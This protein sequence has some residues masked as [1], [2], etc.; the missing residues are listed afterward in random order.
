[1]WLAALDRVG[2]APAYAPVYGPAGVDLSDVC[3]QHGARRALEI[4]AAGGHNMFFMGPPGAGKTMLA[5]R[6]PTILPAMTMVEALEVTAIHS[7]NGLL[8]VERGVLTMR[9]F[10]A[11]HHTVS[12]AGLVG[13]GDPVRPGEV[14]LAHNG[15]LFLDEVL[16]FKS[17][18][19][20]ALRQPLEDGHATLVRSGQRAT[21]PARPLLVTAVNPCPCG[22]AG[23]RAGRCTCT[24][25]RIRNYRVRLN[26]PLMSRIDLHVVLPPVDATSLHAAGRGE[27]S[28]V[29]RERVIASRAVQADRARRLGCAATNAQLGPRDLERVATPDQAG[30]RILAAAVER[31]GISAHAYGAVLRVARTI[32]DMDE[33]DAVRAP[34]VAEAVHARVLDRATEPTAAN[35][36]A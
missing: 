23:E 36:V 5:K 11:P 17:A 12:A 26:G 21:F 30:A 19:L 34:H 25:E 13:G 10:R 4:A 32:A 29:V 18:V 28:A 33:S 2:V 8:G 20:E 22:Y 3:G 27:T 16:E 15:V 31:L 1:M 9:P 6:L 7:V 24:A 35:R 14:S